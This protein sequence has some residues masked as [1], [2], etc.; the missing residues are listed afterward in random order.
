MICVK[1]WIGWEWKD[2]D[3]DICLTQVQPGFLSIYPVLTFVKRLCSFSE[4]DL[5]KYIYIYSF[6]TRLIHR[7][8]YVLLINIFEC[9]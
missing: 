3:M 9:L 6:F 5:F 7:L 8:I 2:I 1:D 4:D